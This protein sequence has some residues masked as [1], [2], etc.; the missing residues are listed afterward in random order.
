M[1]P[2]SKVK[3]NALNNAV[4]QEEVV[5]PHWPPLSP[6]SDPIDLSLDV[7][8]ADQIVTVSGLWTSSLCKKYVSFLAG[9]P[10]VTT[11]GTPKRGE[12]VRVNDR[13]QIQDPAFARRLWEETALKELVIN[14]D[15]DGK[16][17]SAAERSKLWGGDVVG[18]NPNI[19]VYRYS[20]G[21]FFDQ[22]CRSP[23]VPIDAT[24]GSC[25]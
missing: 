2:K 7:L 11:P 19:R 20:K 21:Q 8:V 3:Q 14:G 12:A 16:A 18:L 25:R 1:A 13:Y 9:L 4:A 6:L 23:R 24:L 5:L 17:F 10:L 22:H 15:I